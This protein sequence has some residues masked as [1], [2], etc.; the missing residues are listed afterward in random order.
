[1]AGTADRINDDLM[2]DRDLLESIGRVTGRALGQARQW[3]AHGGRPDGH[4]RVGIVT[5]QARPQAMAW[6]V[7]GICFR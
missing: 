7:S 2:P 6:A 4:D 1:M 5:A 3:V